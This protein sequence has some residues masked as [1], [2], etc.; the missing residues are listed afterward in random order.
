MSRF[1][2]SED[3]KK[4]MIKMFNEG[5]SVTLISKCVGFRPNTVRMFLKG[6]GL[7]TSR[8]RNNE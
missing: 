3:Q 5:V 4:R 2:I 6:A 8:R 1:K 7:D